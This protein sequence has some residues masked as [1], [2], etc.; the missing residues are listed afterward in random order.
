MFDRFITL[1]GEDNFN[2]IS[3]LK[4]LIVGIGGV[5][6]YAL[7]TLVRSG[8]KNITIIDNDNIEMTNL[9][10][11]IVTNSSNIGNKKVIEAS[12]RA[13]LINPDININTLDIFLDENN[14][15][16]IITN[17][18]DY[19]IDSCDTINTKIALIK[20]CYLNKIKLISC[21]GT[22]KKLDAIKLK[23]TTLD[24]T[25]YDPI[26]KKLRSNLTDKEKK[27]TIVISSSE[28]YKKIDKL[29]STS[30]VPATAGLLITNYIVNDIVNKKD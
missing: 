22:A 21:M 6:G 18:Y 3:N 25:N 11:Q 5:G 24:K 29:G 1:I 19:I 28:E 15:K 8:I 13:L 20:H 7:E 4:I 2:K 17:D 12:K 23:I 16:N 10:R 27:F 30:Y 9:N 14:I 26:A